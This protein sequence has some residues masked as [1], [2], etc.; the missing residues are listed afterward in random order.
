M[1]Y[2]PFYVKHYKGQNHS[3]VTEQTGGYLGL[4]GVGCAGG[5]GHLQRNT[6]EM[7]KFSTTT[8]VMVMPLY[9]LGIIH[10][11]V[12]VELARFLVSEFYLDEVPKQGKRR[13]PGVNAI[14]TILSLI[15]ATALL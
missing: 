9:L 1:L 6:R 13:G 8:V 5:R 14:P 3:D 7:T 4:G 12:R 15:Q 11:I 10:Q 2:D